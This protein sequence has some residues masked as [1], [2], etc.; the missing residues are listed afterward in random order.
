M[1]TDNSEI[2]YTNDGE[3][4][5]DIPADAPRAPGGPWNVY[6]EYSSGRCVVAKRTPPGGCSHQM[7]PTTWQRCWAWIDQRCEPAGGGFGC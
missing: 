3:P 1:N 7:G 2:F 4:T 5:D 6:R